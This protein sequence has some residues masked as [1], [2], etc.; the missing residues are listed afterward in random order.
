[1]RCLVHQHFAE[2][3]QVATVL[4]SVRSYITS[5]LQVAFTFSG[6]SPDRTSTTGPLEHH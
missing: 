3:I 2:N 6:S 5:A 1:M 4:R